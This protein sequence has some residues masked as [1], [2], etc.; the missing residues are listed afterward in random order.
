MTTK[1]HLYSMCEEYV[2]SRIQRIQ[3]SLKDLE[4]DMESEGKNSAGDKYETGREMMSEEWNKLSN[5]LKE[6]KQQKD[7]LK[8]AKNREASKRIQLGCLVKTSASN[9]FISIPVGKMELDK[10]T[11][12]GVGAN[13]PVARLLMG[14]TEGDDFEFNG[15]KNKIFT[16]D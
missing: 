13:S 8:L 10:H 2:E 7:T 5:Q 12:Y 4:E 11:F 1:D 3:K 15:I 14:K 16:V 6:F 9:Y